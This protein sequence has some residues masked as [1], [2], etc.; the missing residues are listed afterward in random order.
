MSILRNKTQSLPGFYF[1]LIPV[2]KDD[3]RKVWD[4]KCDTL[5]ELNEWSQCLNLAIELADQRN[6]E[7][8][9]GSA[10]SSSSSRKQ[11]GFISIR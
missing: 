9:A 7:G 5:D 6:I 3:E 1:R 4:F 8:A 2:E 11:L 10:D